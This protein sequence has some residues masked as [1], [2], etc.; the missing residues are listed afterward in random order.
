MYKLTKCDVVLGDYC[1]SSRAEGEVD[2]CLRGGRGGRGKVEVEH[3]A[4]VVAPARTLAATGLAPSTSR[5][6]T[7]SVRAAEVT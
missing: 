1:L 5:A 4:Q 7:V 2:E 3:T 6:R